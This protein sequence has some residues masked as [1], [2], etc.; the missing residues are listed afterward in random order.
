MFNSFRCDKA[1]KYFTASEIVKK[2]REIRR[3]KD[4]KIVERCLSGQSPEFDHIMSEIRKASLLGENDVM[5]MKM[6]FFGISQE[7]EVCLK[8]QGFEVTSGRHAVFWVNK[9][10]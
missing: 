9:F 1:K 7:T 2:T 4:K 3:A 6:L 8:H 10:Y 5:T